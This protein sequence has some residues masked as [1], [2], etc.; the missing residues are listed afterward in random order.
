[1]S[2]CTHCETTGVVGVMCDRCKIAE[3]VEALE[4]IVYCAELCDLYGDYSVAVD[5]AKDALKK[6]KE[7]S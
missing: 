1:M 6:H 2:K 7:V 4:E 3:L 5:I